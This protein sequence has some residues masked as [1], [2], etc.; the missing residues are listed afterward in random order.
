MLFNLPDYSLIAAILPI[1]WAIYLKHTSETGVQIHINNLD[2]CT[3]ICIRNGSNNALFIDGAICYKSNRHR[4]KFYS[5]N[6]TKSL[7]IASGEEDHLILDT[8][9]FIEFINTLNI[10]KKRITGT[11][12]KTLYIPW[13]P[14]NWLD[15]VG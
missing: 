2:Y 5:S 8:D 3:T 15:K 13:C 10:N 6:S 1:I 12:N 14:N 11:Q 4:Y 9:Q 7:M